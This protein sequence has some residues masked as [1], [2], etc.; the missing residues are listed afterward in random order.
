[1]FSLLS[2]PYLLKLLLSCVFC[3]ALLP[4]PIY[5]E[6]AWVGCY[7]QLARAPKQIEEA[8]KIL[9]EI[10][11]A[12]PP[13]DSGYAPVRKFIEK[14]LASS[15]ADFITKAQTTPVRELVYTFVMNTAADFVESGEYHI[16]RGVVNPMGPGED[17]VRIFNWSQDELLQM[18]ATDEETVKRS[19]EAFNRNLQGVG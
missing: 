14:Y 13:Q 8:L 17:F 6:L 12:Q 16:Y 18:G 5:W 9:D 19:K 10:Q 2:I 4:A 15:P 11:A 3:A 1:L 7:R